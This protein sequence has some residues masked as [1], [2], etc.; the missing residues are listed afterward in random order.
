MARL[1][2]DLALRVA[3][4]AKAA[5]DGAI[6]EARG[7]CAWLPFALRI[8]HEVATAGDRLVGAKERVALVIDRR[9]IEHVADEP[10]GHF[11]ELKDILRVT[12]L[13]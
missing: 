11:L 12:K 10:L 2:I 13:L 6:N 8:P 9:R 1:L 4:D 5:V 3:G 7:V